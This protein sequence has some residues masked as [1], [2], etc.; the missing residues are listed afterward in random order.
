[1][2]FDPSQSGQRRVTW[3]TLFA[4]TGTLVCCALPILFVS[5][6]LGATVAAITSTAPFLVSLAMHK[7]WVFAGSGLMLLVSGWLLYRPGRACPSDPELGR[8]CE[9]A[10]RWNR[11]IHGISAAVWSIGFFAAYLALPIRIWL[12][13]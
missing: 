4:S 11:R 3:L 8:L 12:G 7:A 2:N 6:G 9:R 5:L 1:M 10:D 13:Y